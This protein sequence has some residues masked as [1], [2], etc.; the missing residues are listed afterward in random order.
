MDLNESLDRFDA[1]LRHR[2]RGDDLRQRLLALDAVRD[3]FGSYAALEDPLRLR[4]DDLREF[5]FSMI[6]DGEA[7]A[8]AVGLVLGVLR[9]WLASLATELDPARRQELGATLA[10]LRQDV[11]RAMAAADLLRECVRQGDLSA[12]VDL[13]PEEDGERETPLASASAGLDRVARLD[14][15]DYSRGE[16]DD[17]EIAAVGEA[18]VTLRR[19]AA[20]G[21]EP[22]LGPVPIPPAA[23]AQLRPG[24]ILSAEIAPAGEDWEL[25][26]VQAV[27]PGGYGGRH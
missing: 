23:A 9:D 15:V 25:L 26:D 2:S 27:Y 13:V 6:H 11:P 3:Y 19:P 24:D 12:A 5:A 4:A 18:D 21:D 14:E 1:A 20:A 16:Q 7:D 10:G 22:R 17:W 8:A